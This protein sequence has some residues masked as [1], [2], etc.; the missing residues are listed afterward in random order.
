VE[1]KNAVEIKNELEVFLS[2]FNEYYQTL[3]SQGNQDQRTTLRYGLQRQEPRITKLLLEII[4]NSTYVLGS[5]GAGTQRPVALSDLIASAT[6]GGNNEYLHNFV[7]FHVAVTSAINKAIG[8]IEAGNWP[9][10]EPNPILVIKDSELK[11]RCSDLLSAPGSYDRIIRESTTILESR[12]RGKC[13]HDLLAR[14]IPQAADQT[15]ENLINK[16]LN[17]DKPILLTSSD[18][19]KRL[20]F[21]RILLG[22]NSYLRNPTHHA[23]DQ[24]TE[25]S[26]AWSIVGLIDQVLTD[27]GNCT[28]TDGQ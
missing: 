12:I 26:W 24:N 7:D 28:V 25:W 5:A 6:L 16:L 15:G 2:K 20:A 23:I 9:S 27:V 4:G 8:E 3:K 17:P 22:I 10:S 14:I 21:H 19:H 18:K 1:N 13:P 11:E